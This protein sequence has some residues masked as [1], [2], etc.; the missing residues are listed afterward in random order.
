MDV[1]AEDGDTVELRIPPDAAYVPMLRT[2]SMSL[3]A[4]CDLT[5]DQIEDLGIAVDEAC[6]LLL[7][8]AAPGGQV[9]ARFVVDAGRLDVRIQIAARPGAEPDEDGFAWTV[10]HAVVE[11]V[12][13]DRGDGVLAI[14]LGKR[15]E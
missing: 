6:T 10:L 9:D 13:V 7:P 12:R 11:E 1:T 2:L 8:A 14:G 3:A 5:V 15:R 4:R